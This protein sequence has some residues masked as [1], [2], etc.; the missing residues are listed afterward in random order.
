MP[1]ATSLPSKD[2]LD[3][4][5][6]Y[7]DGNLYWR[8]TVSTLAQAGTKAGCVNGR[9]YVAV[10]LHYKKYLVHRLIWVMHGNDPVD[11]IDHIN[12]DVTDNRIENLRASTHAENMC[13]ARISKRNSSGIKG[14]SWSKSTNKW[15]GSVW[16]EHKIYK[17]PGFEKKEECAESVK[18]LRASLHGEFACHG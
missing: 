17:T 3:E 10:G 12:G 13:N 11:V 7:R 15:V 6:E 1:A 14:V 16:F 9:G 2:Q 5:F 4:L 18:T 8:K